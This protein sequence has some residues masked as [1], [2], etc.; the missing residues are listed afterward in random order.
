MVKDVGKQRDFCGK[1][2]PKHSIPLTLKLLKMVIK[3]FI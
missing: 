2:Q 3:V 1:G